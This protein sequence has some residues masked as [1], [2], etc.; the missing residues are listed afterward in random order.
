MK[1]RI[2]F[3]LCFFAA[4]PALAEI[5]GKSYVDAHTARTDNPHNVTAAQVGL[6]N[7][8][9]LDQTNAANITSGTLGIA[10][11]PVGTD[12]GTV[13]AG[14]DARFDTVKTSE[15][16]AAAPAGRAKIWFQN[17]CIQVRDSSGTHT[18]CGN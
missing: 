14:D 3:L 5:A 2:M 17:G 18:L 13:A 6:G 7:V 10:R 9:N 11:I 12:T 8:Q 15:P 1:K 4:T 16:S